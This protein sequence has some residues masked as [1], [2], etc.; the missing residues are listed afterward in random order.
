[1]VIAQSLLTLEVTKLASWSLSVSTG[2]ALF[3]VD[4]HYSFIRLVWYIYQYFQGL[5]TSIVA[6]VKTDTK[7]YGEIDRYQTINFTNMD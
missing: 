7:E 3:S 2:V 1:M 5:L 6:I 4:F